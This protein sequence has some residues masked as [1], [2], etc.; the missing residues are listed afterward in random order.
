LLD[1]GGDLTECVA[2]ALASQEEK[3]EQRWSRREMNPMLR[4]PD[5]SE[6]VPEHSTARHMD[7]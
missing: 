3:I 7:I 2:V 4:E 1:N 6:E 5:D